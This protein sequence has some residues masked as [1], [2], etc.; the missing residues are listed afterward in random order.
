MEKHLVNRWKMRVQ[1]WWIVRPVY[2]IDRQQPTDGNWTE[3]QNRERRKEKQSVRERERMYSHCD[4]LRGL[5]AF[6][7]YGV[8]A[9]VRVQLG[10][11]AVH[12]FT[13]V[14][15]FVSAY[16]TTRQIRWRNAPETL[17]WAPCCDRSAL[18]WKRGLI[19]FKCTCAVKV[20]A[21]L[22]ESKKWDR[23][24]RR[25]SSSVTTASLIHQG[26]IQQRTA[27]SRS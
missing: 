11:W 24:K 23:G 8:N 15:A 14:A 27:A 18:Q 7:F 13:C 9:C 12:H 10:C 21:G 25:A 6:Y 3:R 26:E 16:L 4:C 5:I 22:T 19:F 2:A 1:K 17:P 20:T